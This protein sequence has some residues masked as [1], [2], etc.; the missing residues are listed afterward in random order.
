M[1]H[2]DITS[3]PLVL[4]DV[5]GVINDLGH[6]AGHSRPWET[7]VF[8]ANGFRIHIPDYMPHLIQTIAEITEIHWCTTWRD[9]ANSEIA[10]AL[11]V[12]PFP[13]IDDGTDAM[14]PDWKAAA[15][16]DLVS[17]AIG[18]ARSVIWIED[19][20]GDVPTDLMPAGVEY[21]DTALV[22]H[23]AVLIPELLPPELLPV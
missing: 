9:R 20:Y 22:P 2:C 3:R 17:K 15:A 6:L 21:V 1:G 16:Y 19:F 4:L 7:R 12:G 8:E 14:Y 18:D 11:G 5:D 13:V 10:P 23:G